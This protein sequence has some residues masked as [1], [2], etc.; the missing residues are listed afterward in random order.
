LCPTTS[1]FSV[2]KKRVIFFEKSAEYHDNYNVWNVGWGCHG[3][4]WGIFMSF[5]RVVILVNFAAN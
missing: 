2:L 3:M 5:F 1:R 4:G